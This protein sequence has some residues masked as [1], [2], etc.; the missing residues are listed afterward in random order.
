M[1]WSGNSA[2]DYAHGNNGVDGWSSNQRHGT[3]TSAT[4]TT[5]ADRDPATDGPQ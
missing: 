4:S 1:S 5:D 3:T 2:P